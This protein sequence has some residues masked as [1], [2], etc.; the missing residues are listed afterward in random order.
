ME[1]LLAIAT[2][3]GTWFLVVTIPGPNFIMVTR[4]AMTE[5]RSLG[6]ST[7]MGISVG[8]GVWAT[9][10]LFGLSV[11]F[12]YAEWLY[13]LIRF[14]GG[15]YLV[16]IGIK[17]IKSAFSKKQRSICS[18]EY[19]NRAWVAFRQGLFTSFS[20][21]KTATF[22]GSLFITTFPPQ[23]PLWGY[24]STIIIVFMVSLIWYSLVACFF[25]L[26]GTQNTYVRMK[27]K[28][29]G[30]TGCLLAFLGVRLLISRT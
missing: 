22:F 7:A 18:L 28:L 8:A 17:T 5:S 9:A 3:G 19:P 25:S 10:S 2:L 6:L 27:P 11:L 26:A 16:F 24:I 13:S 14:I 23:A 15:I 29:D 20:N 21:P 4:Y 12:E 1:L 30:L